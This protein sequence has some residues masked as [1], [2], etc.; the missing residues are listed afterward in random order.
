MRIVTVRRGGHLIGALPLYLH[1]GH[2]SPVW[3]HYLGFLSTGESRS[4]ATCPEYLDLLHAPG[5]ARACRGRHAS[6]AARPR[7][8]PVGHPGLVRYRR[9][10]ASAGLAR[11]GASGRPG[12]GDSSR[13]LPVGVGPER[14]PPGGGPR[15]EPRGITARLALMRYPADRGIMGYDFLR[16]SLEYKSQWSTTCKSLV[17]L[18]LVRPG[19]RAAADEVF[20]A[21]PSGRSDGWWCRKFR[22]LGVPEPRLVPTRTLSA[23]LRGPSRLR[24]LAHSR[25]AV[26]IPRREVSP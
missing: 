10:L 1:I 6:R 26:P 3:A 18:R 7:G 11:S 9:G 25:R 16:R 21:S 23:L 20:E 2:R 12:R 24:K 4:E 22:P 5:E 15:Q 19:F 14:R 17:R 8:G 13:S